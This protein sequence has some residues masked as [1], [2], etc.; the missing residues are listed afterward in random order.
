MATNRKR[1]EE[2]E[3]DFDD[4]PR[5]KK[6]KSGGGGNALIFGL[7]GGGL[8]LVAGIA[9]AVVILTKDR[10]DSPP[11]T[12]TA[13]TDPKGKPR[14]HPGASPEQDGLPPLT[15]AHRRRPVAEHHPP[16]ISVPQTTGLR[17]GTDRRAV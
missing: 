9:A 7:I 15:G 10:K 17:A 13:G 3:D 11:A 6:R 4:R 16:R 14:H 2:D 5:R 1:Y 8:L 12:E